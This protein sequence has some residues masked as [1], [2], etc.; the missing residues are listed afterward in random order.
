MPFSTVFHM[1]TCYT[2]NTKGRCAH[3][4]SLSHQKQPNS[5][6][7]VRRYTAL[8][9][10]CLLPLPHT[11]LS[12]PCWAVMHLLWNQQPCCSSGEAQ[13]SPCH[14]HNLNTILAKPIKDSRL[15]LWLPPAGRGC[16]GLLNGEVIGEHSRKERKE[17]QCQEGRNPGDSL[18][19]SLMRK[20]SVRVIE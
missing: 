5:A 11:P 8:V 1:P 14:Q 20:R 6:L 9:A 4:A 3:S 13:S 7:V 10:A 19:S 18:T 17:S 15:Q 12:A 16:V 2:H